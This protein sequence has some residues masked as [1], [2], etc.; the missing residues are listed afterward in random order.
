MRLAA[1][2]TEI[3]QAAGPVL[4]IDLAK[5]L[6]IEPSEIAA[7]LTALRAAGRL[8][9]EVASGSAMADCAPGGACSMTCPGPDECSLTMDLS[10]SG[11]EVRR[12]T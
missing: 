6:G 2:L 3:E 5:R 1:L 8:G 10:L 9:P 12:P 7:M 4:G 11:L